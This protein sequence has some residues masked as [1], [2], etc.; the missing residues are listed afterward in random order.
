MINVMKR[1]MEYGLGVWSN[2]SGAVSDTPHLSLLIH[3]R[4]KEAAHGVD[5]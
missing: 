4:E 1:R 2:L 5:R 3:A